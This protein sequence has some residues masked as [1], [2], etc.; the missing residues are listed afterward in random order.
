[1][2]GVSIL[3]TVVKVI[4]EQ[5]LTGSEGKRY[6]DIWRVFS[7]VETAEAMTL[8]CAYCVQKQQIGWYDWSQASNGYIVRGE[9][10]KII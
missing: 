2:R 7:A 5:T 3:N 4:Y 6:E 10:K 8:K 9:L 1:M